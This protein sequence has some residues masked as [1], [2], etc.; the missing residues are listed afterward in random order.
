MLP[1]AVARKSILD[2]LGSI[3][4]PFDSDLV[5]PVEPE[6]LSEWSP[7]DKPWDVHKA[8]A[9]QVSQIFNSAPAGRLHR[10]AVR[11][12]QC[13]E[14]L[15]YAWGQSRNDPGEFALKLKQAHFCHV[16][17]CPICQ[18]RRSMIYLARFLEALP[19]LTAENPTARWL[20]LG[21]TCRNM[22]VE[23]LRIS[24]AAMNKAWDRLAKKKAF[25][26]VRGW[27]RTTEVT[28]S[29]VG[30]AH[31]HF[32]VLLMVNSNYFTKN[33]ITQ[34]AWTEMWRQS[35]RVD[36]QPIVDIEVVKPKAGV[37]GLTAGIRE[38][39][40][41]AVKPSDMTSNAEWFLE[42]TRQLHKLRFIATGGLLK[43]IL[44]ESEETQED[45]LLAG[46]GEVE[47]EAEEK[48]L[49]F[50]YSHQVHRYRKRV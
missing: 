12:G 30:E 42:L 44:R 19:K 24:L 6:F 48:P 13:A 43:N 8:Q 32:H 37:D 34:A 47:L 25:G 20:F 16:R 26:V 27:V 5:A 39:L 46:E 9:E 49:T 40:K 15:V 36:Y 1:N 10:W 14:W 3:V 22:P 50:D 23:E 33:Y 11:V 21:L 7:R 45:L 2:E 31:P 17:L 38:T 35:L 4:K 41:Y 29:H 18:W 28:R